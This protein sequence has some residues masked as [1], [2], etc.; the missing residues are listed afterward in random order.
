MDNRGFSL[1]ELSIA[2]GA[3]AVL[4]TA[5]LPAAIRS[6]EIKA[7]EKTVTEVAIIQEAARKFR[8]EQKSWPASLVQMQTLQ[9][10]APQW[11][12]LNPWNDPY[13]ISSNANTF[14]VAAI[15]PDNLVS[16]LAFRLP[17][18]SVDGQKVTSVIGTAGTGTTIPT[19][20]IVAWSGTI[21]DI[22][23]G[24]G[25]CD[26]T[27]GAPDLRDKFIVGARQD[28]QGVAK[29]NVT[30]ALT[31][32]GGTITHNHAGTTGSHTLTAAQIPPAQITLPMFSPNQASPNAP[33]IQR[34]QNPADGSL[35]LSTNGGGQGHTHTIPSDYHVPPY[36][37]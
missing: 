10:L 11:S 4:A 31:Q 14:S 26:G 16:M 22:P 15:V 17:Q 33:T 35:T 36:Y 20:V 8:N 12:L 28:A 30:G 23:S 37:A 3:I 29:S 1:I 19:G 9:Y 18:A 6:L 21:A 2:M 34:G 25:L 27:N 32:S 7:G 24:W 5:M 13:Q